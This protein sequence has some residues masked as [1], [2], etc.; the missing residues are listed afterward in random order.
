MMFIGLAIFVGACVVVLVD[1]IVVMVRY[2]NMRGVVRMMTLGD[3]QTYKLVV[4]RGLSERSRVHTNHTDY[5][6]HTDHTDHTDITDIIALGS[7]CIR[8]FQ[9]GFGVRTQIRCRVLRVA[10]RVRVFGE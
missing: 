7:A 2:H 1:G 10:P 3:V 6:D 9:E 4:M 8:S 5:T